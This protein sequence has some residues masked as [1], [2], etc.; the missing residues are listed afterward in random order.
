MST[1][2]YGPFF[3]AHG[4]EGKLVKIYPCDPAPEDF[5]ICSIGRGLGSESRFVGQTLGFWPVASHSVEC[6]YVP[7]A[8]GSEPTPEERF[9]CLMHDTSEGAGM[10]DLPTPIKKAPEMEL[11]TYRRSDLR[12]T[13]AIA[14]KYALVEGFHEKPHVKHADAVLYRT[15]VR[16]LRQPRSW[17]PTEAI[18]DGPTLPYKLLPTTP[19]AAER[20]FLERFIELCE[21]T[22]RKEAAAE[23]RAALSQVPEDQLSRASAFTFG[24]PGL[25]EVEMVRM[26]QRDGRSLWSIH[27][28]GGR[29]SSWTREGHW[30]YQPMASSRDPDFLARARW[31]FRE[32]W[33]ECERIVREGLNLP[34]RLD[35]D[36]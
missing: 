13:D 2:R 26:H 10:R 27:R 25:H 30:E 1:H 8:D 12:V 5:Y 24:T 29:N 34:R 17:T 23:G 32:A 14:R 33:A 15:E 7:R 11:A 36:E 4:P 20:R 28:D 22:G 21:L 16:D 18:D 3:G 19:L 9:E 6:S 31:E 35:D